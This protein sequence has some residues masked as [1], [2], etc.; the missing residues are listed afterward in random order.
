[1]AVE[2]GEPV[3]D[4]VRR[5]EVKLQVSLAEADVPER[6]NANPSATVAEVSSPERRSSHSSMNFGFSA[7]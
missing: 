7:S 6:T 3:V 2:L 1:M 4:E 5:R